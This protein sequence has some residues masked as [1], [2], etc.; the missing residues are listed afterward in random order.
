MNSLHALL[1]SLL[2]LAGC[3][4]GGGGLPLTLP[5][6]RF[7]SSDSHAGICTLDG[8][9]RFV[10][11]YLDEVYLWYD[12]I[13]GVDAA[14]F[15]NI[16][17]YFDALLVRTPDANGR[18]RDQFSAVL[19]L[20]SAEAV[21]ARSLAPAEPAP[22]DGVLQDHTGAVPVSRVVTSPDGR[23]TGYI[24][25]TDHA[26]GAQDD[27]ITAFRAIRDAGA[28]DLVLDLRANSG[29][30]LYIAAAAASMVAGPG[31]EGQV[32]E[33]LRYNDKRTAETAAGT[34]KFSSRV[35]FAE[36]QYPTGTPLPQL[37]LPR[38]YVL[39]SG[40]T[41]SSSE[42]IINGLR[43]VDV[44]VILVGDT[45]CGKPYGFR[46]RNNCGYAFFPIEFQ[47]T[48]A[49]GF[50]DYTAGFQP[51][52]RVQDAPDTVAGGPDDPLLEAALF[53]IDT[54]NC[55]TASGRSAQSRGTAILTTPT[56]A[57]PAWAGRLLL[58]E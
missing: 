6:S 56:P 8:Q 52:C 35:Q 45:T 17:D 11:S 40:G 24:Q 22:F 53:H 27:L 37:D 57:R 19:P 54:G 48:N 9:K 31:H 51:T 36:D 55:P 1:L 43:G 34:L 38:L 13:P 29:G 41:C 46:Q 47:G 16:P 39:T 23:R 20:A 14:R 5:S 4:G 33:H 2:L 30:F 15:G 49:K 3:G 21:L 50:G 12:E 26:R 7:G 18:P 28:Q 10:R 32:F 44:Q 25:F 42:S 58:P